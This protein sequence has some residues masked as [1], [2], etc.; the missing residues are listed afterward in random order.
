[1]PWKRGQWRHLSLDPQTLEGQGE[2]KRPQGSQ[3]GT[4]RGTGGEA[5]AASWGHRGGGNHH[6]WGPTVAGSGELTAENGAARGLGR[7][8]SVQKQLGRMIWCVWERT[9]GGNSD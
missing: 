4:T 1:M 7:S 5:G 8:S 9:R 2:D 3:E 6:L